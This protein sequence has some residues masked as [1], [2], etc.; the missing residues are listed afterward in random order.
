MDGS[1][2]WTDVCATPSLLHLS[3]THFPRPRSRLGIQDNPSEKSILVRRTMDNLPRSFTD[4]IL[5]WAIL[6]YRYTTVE[7][8]KNFTLKK[9][10]TRLP[11]S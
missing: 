9:K 11:D 3:L 7:L 5:S 2:Q 8:N 4:V 6:S 1:G 10:E